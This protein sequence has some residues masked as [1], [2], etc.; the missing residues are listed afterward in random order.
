MQHLLQQ[1]KLGIFKNQT[2]NETS[3]Y[4]QSLLLNHISWTYEVE[5]FGFST[6]PGN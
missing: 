6:T 2:R 4:H 3:F 1:K 5:V